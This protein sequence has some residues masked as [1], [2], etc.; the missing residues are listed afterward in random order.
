MVLIIPPHSGCASR[1]GVLSC[2]VWDSLTHSAARIKKNGR[3][4]CADHRSAKHFRLYLD[5]SVRI[6]ALEIFAEAAFDGRNSP[7]QTSLFLI[8]RGGMKSR[9]DWSYVTSQILLNHGARLKG[10]QY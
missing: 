4:A 8:G 7:P 5:L 1:A 10:K 2:R 6:G 3:R 9:Y